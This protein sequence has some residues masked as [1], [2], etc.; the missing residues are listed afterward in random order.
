MPVSA[1]ER[2]AV[3]GIVDSRGLGGLL[4]EVYAYDI[5]NA[6]GRVFELQ[7]PMLAE[8]PA[9][10]QPEVVDQPTEPLGRVADVR[11][12]QS[13]HLRGVVDRVRDTDEFVLRDDSGSI[14][15]YIGWR[16]RMPVAAGDVVTVYGVAD[17]DVF[18]GRRPEVYARRIITA[19]GREITLRRGGYDDE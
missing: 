15:V 5:T 13:V 19:D 1:G 11:R 4:K 8:A 6:Q 7:R 14:R 16:N 10:A 9:R 3:V 12:G 17:D 18:P 2:V